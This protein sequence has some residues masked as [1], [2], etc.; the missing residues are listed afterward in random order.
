MLFSKLK[1]GF[2]NCEG[3]GTAFL[4]D[5]VETFGLSR[6]FS[7]SVFLESILARF[8]WRSSF[9]GSELEKNREKEAERE[10]ERER[11]RERERGRERKEQEE[12]ET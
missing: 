5:K 8:L 3:F 9:D 7:R 6:P 4:R 10:R 12:T 11:K 1:S 2:L